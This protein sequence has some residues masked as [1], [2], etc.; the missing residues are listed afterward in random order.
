MARRKSKKL[1]VQSVVIS[2]VLL[3]VILAGYFVYTKFFKPDPIDAKGEISFHFMM[4]GNKNAG[5]CVYVKA[6]ENDILIDAGSKEN[7]IDDIKNYIDDYVTDG[8][9]EYVI[10][11]HAH[12]DHIAGFSKNDGSL[13]DLY[14]CQTIID[15]PRSESTSNI[16]SRYQ[17][18]RDAEVTNGAKHYTALECWNNTNGAQRV[19]NLT[20]DGNIKL[21]ILYNYY[22]EHDAKDEND[23]SVCVQFSHGDRKFIFTGDL[24]ADGEEYLIEYNNLTQVEL[25]KAGHHGSASS[26]SAEFMAKIKPKAC[27]VC[28]CAGCDEYRA[29]FYNVFPSQTFINNIAP[30]T[31]KIYI[32]VMMDMVFVDQGN[33]PSDPSDDNYDNTD[34]EVEIMNGNVVIISDAEQGVYADCSNNNTILKDTEW[35]SKFRFWPT[36][37]VA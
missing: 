16:Y 28:C 19:Y 24:E 30:Y 23:Y 7:S 10:V 18:E 3:I 32:P 25:Y 36:G 11:T 5:D 33:D 8:K 27:V 14:E 20:E 15:F 9:L 22:Y 13:F 1:K 21:E 35:F 31:S 2:I 29:D 34:K 26:T 6:G 12:E 17:S 4:L 37:G